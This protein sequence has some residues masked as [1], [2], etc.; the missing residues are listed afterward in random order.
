MQ[1]W[2]KLELAH[3]QIRQQLLDTI[4]MAENGIRIAEK[5]GDT[6]KPISELP[7]FALS[8]TNATWYHMIRERAVESLAKF[9]ETIAKK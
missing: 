4:K 3:G 7:P 6:E 9:E 1:D 5:C 2:K 8:A